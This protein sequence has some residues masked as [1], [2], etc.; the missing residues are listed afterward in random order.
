MTLPEAQGKFGLMLT[1]HGD[2]I[3]CAC[4]LGYM[5]IHGARGLLHCFFIVVKENLLEKGSNVFCT[6]NV[7]YSCT[8]WKC[9]TP[10]GTMS[11]KLTNL[12]D[13]LPWDFSFYEMTTFPDNLNHFE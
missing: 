5:W 10:L 9:E 4:L 1:T 12:K 7:A 8:T 11:P 2:S 3:P 13:T 6:K